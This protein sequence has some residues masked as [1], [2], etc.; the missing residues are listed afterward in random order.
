MSSQ[1]FGWVFPFT[2]VKHGL[3]GP[4]SHSQVQHCTKTHSILHIRKNSQMLLLHLPL[5]LY[6]VGPTHRDRRQAVQI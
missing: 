5:G 2:T 6:W 1:V 3:I 4:S